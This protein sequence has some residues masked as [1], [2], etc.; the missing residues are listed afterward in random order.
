MCVSCFEGSGVVQRLICEAA[1]AGPTVWKLVALSAVVLLLVKHIYNYR[2]K[3]VHM[4]VSMYI[5]I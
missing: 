2:C 4:F 1:P 5:C 3:Y